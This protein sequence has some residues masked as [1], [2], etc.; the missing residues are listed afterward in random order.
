MWL[1]AF[2]AFALWGFWPSYYSRLS[3]PID[4]H[5]HLHGLAL[6]A[7]CVMLVAEA[8]FMRGGKRRTHRR[9]GVLSYVLV[10][11]LAATTL[12]LVHF[13]MSGGSLPDI[14]FYQFAL[15]FNA[16]VCFVV[17]YALAMIYRRQPLVHARFMICTI[18]PL[19]TPVTDRLIYVHWPSLVTSVPA[20]DGVPLVQVLGF[21]LADVLLAAL[22][23]WDWLK[24]RRFGAFASA[25]GVVALYQLSV[26]TFYRFEWW[27]SFTY[28]FRTLTLP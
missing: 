9:L 5:F 26:L 24:N 16:V 15:M 10:P 28:W 3:A 18:F 21:A 19:F 23:A 6:T 2:F 7:W 11:V 12:S 22:I 1:V 14:G 17:L 13:R 20:L 4:I 25:L 27:H 8:F